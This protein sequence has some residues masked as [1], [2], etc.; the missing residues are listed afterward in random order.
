MKSIILRSAL[1]TLLCSASVYA[2]DTGLEEAMRGLSSQK[3]MQTEAFSFAKMQTAFINCQGLSDKDTGRM[4]CRYNYKPSKEWM[5]FAEFTADI[6]MQFSNVYPHLADKYD[7]EHLS[8]SPNEVT[9]ENLHILAPRF[10]E[11]TFLI[12]WFKKLGL[13]E[14]VE[15]SSSNNS[16]RIKT[17]EVSFAGMT[18]Q[19]IRCSGVSYRD[20]DGDRNI[21]GYT[22]TIWRYNPS[23]ESMPFADFME[24]MK[25]QF[26]EKRPT[27]FEKYE[28]QEL[29]AGPQSVTEENFHILGP[30]FL[31]NANL[32][33][34]V[35]KKQ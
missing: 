33:L 3:S 14:K 28:V 30:R 15:N 23:K 12:V 1:G 25:R 11:N 27:L 13:E 22:G 7:V 24:D 29:I 5:T 18:S 10:L 21:T 31:E 34:V 16:K 8:F 32:M 9:K 17:E 35:T 6:K 2:T 26:K 19:V 20:A 4:N